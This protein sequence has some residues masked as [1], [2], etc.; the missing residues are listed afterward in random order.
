MNG[1]TGNSKHPTY[2]DQF[3]ASAVCMLQ[4]QGY[5]EVEGALTI[6]S[7]HLRVPA[8]TLSR[9]FNGEQN[10]PPDQLVNEKKEDLRSLYLKEIYAVMKVLPEKRDDA[11]YGT[12][13]S[14]QGIFFDKIRLLDNLPTEIVGVLSDVM[15]AIHK[16]GL[17]ASEVF[18][19]MLKELA[20]V[21]ADT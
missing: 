19:A 3:R 5:P 8:R 13:A 16:R 11:S 1:K 7:K 4:S 6:V 2:D 21:D 12:L 14:A 17:K 15:A 20:D 10:P 9:W 18:E